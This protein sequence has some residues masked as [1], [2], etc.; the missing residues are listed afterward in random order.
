MSLAKKTISVEKKDYMDEFKAIL[1]NLEHMDD[2][3]KERL[4]KAAI[5]FF[6]LDHLLKS[7]Y[8]C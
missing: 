8:G 5:K 3:D 1:F 7:E 6:G 2:P 4:L